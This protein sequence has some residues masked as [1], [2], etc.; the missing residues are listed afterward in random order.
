MAATG[1][2]YCPV[3]IPGVNDLR[4]KFPEIAAEMD[5]ELSGFRADQVTSGSGKE[6]WWHCSKGH[7]Y[8]MPIF[9]RTGR[10]KSKCPVCCNKRVVTGVNDLSTLY[11]DIALDFDVEANLESPD[12]VLATSSKQYWWKCHKCGHRWKA[13]MRN[14]T[15]A[16]TGCP[17]CHKG[18]NTSFAE[19]A[20]YLAI[21]ERFRCYN[22][23][24][25]GGYEIDMYIPDLGLCIEYDGFLY[26][27]SE[28]SKNRA[29][30]KEKFILKNGKKLIRIVEVKEGS[31]GCI[32]GT[33]VINRYVGRGSKAYTSKEGIEEVLRELEKAIQNMCRVHTEFHM[34]DKIYSEATDRSAKVP[35]GMSLYDSKPW[36]MQFWRDDLN[37]VSPKALS[38]GSNAR[39]WLECP[40]CHAVYS[41]VANSIVPTCYECGGTLYQE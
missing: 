41:R 28:K 38:A 40:F 6:A 18:A 11:P 1:K 14:R 9:Y 26:H 39:V 32:P 4:T 29:A 37:A 36:I 10:R 17:A 8:S 2:K 7:L 31:T 24:K 13:Y 3:V 27:Q 25:V 33:P 21:A 16:N 22:R 34:T 23:V 30:E 12:E 19:Q 5:E 20:I 35:T 15:L